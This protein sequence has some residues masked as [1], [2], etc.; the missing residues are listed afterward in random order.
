VKA[1]LLAALATLAV[2]ARGSAAPPA[3]L[4]LL[5]GKVFTADPAH[6]WAEAIAIR[7]ERIVAVGE[8]AAVEREAGRGVRRL[9]LGG[10]VV[11]P[12][13]N[14]AHAHVGPEL[15]G[16]PIAVK[17]MEPSFDDVLAAVREAAAAAPAGGSLKGEVGWTALSDPRATRAA[18]DEAA[19]GRPVVL[20]CWTGH[21]GLVSSAVLRAAGIGE[22]SWNPPGG[23]YGHLTG[24]RTLSGALHEYALWRLTRRLR[25]EVPAEQAVRDV[26][27]FEQQALR[28]GI[29][30]VQDMS[31]ALRRDAF[32]RLLAQARPILRWRVITFPMVEPSQPDLDEG[33][34]VPAHPTPLVTVSG[35]KWILDG[36][37]V[38]ARALMRDAY[39]DP[40]GRYGQGNF[41][42]ESVLAAI[43]RAGADPLLLHAVGDRIIAQVIAS[44][45]QL[46]GEA[47]WRPRRLRIEHGDGLMP[48]LVDS[49]RRLGIVVVQNPSH[50]TIGDVLSRRYKPEVRARFQPL[51]SLIAAGIPLALGSDG[52][53]N[54]Y[55]NLMFATTH[56]ARPDEAIDR[57]QAVAAYT[58]GSAYAEFAEG[59]KGTLAPGMLADLAVLSQDVFAVPPGD[60][61]K[62][63]SVLTLVGGKVVYDAGVISSHAKGA[64]LD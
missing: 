58:R 22:E 12:G 45:Q 8:R 61:P 33:P 29:T 7:G 10:R 38:E 25:S 26:H 48:D 23:F 44:M 18:L 49:A 37:P 4:L 30:S 52:P 57:E 3:D 15:P 16:T 35:T 53:V 39:A 19:G 1:G 34:E 32:V 56:P 27:A 42:P 55:L 43:R 36:T 41:R 9:D 20:E 28:F 54:P 17:G 5:N 50:F 47:T 59:E 24:T 2:A 14:D 64:S 11:I 62:T 40:A 6:P 31:N 63:E 13:I 51:R 46:G 21:D 60:L